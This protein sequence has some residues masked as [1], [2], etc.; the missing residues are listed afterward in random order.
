MPEV[1]GPALASVTGRSGL[2]PRP[3]T[4]ADPDG[5]TPLL[6]KSGS[7]CHLQRSDDRDCHVFTS[8]LTPPISGQCA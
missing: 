1:A 5:C 3:G 4:A 2:N 7:E 8:V 6:R